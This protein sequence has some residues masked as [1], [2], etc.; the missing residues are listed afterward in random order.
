MLKKKREGESIFISTNAKSI[1]TQQI[2]NVL[3]EFLVPL[4][5]KNMVNTLGYF[6][7]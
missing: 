4:M 1:T 2:Q 6:T 3:E 7:Y 5:T